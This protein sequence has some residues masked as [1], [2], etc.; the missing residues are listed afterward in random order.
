MISTEILNGQEAG[1]GGE[2]WLREVGCAAWQ[3]L[4]AYDSGPGE[5]HQ[6]FLQACKDA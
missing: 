3:V 2:L 5:E 4:Y 6:E 1:Y